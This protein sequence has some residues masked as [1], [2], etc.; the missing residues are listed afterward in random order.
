MTRFTIKNLKEIDDTGPERGHGIEARFARKHIESDHLGVTY[1]RYS[2][3]VRSTTAHSHRVQEEVY[4]VLSGHGRIRLDDQIVELR[5]W[6]VIR[7]APA[8]LRAVEA[9]PDG[10]EF[11]AVGSDRPDAGDGVHA[12]PA[13]ID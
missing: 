7:I 3:G 2:P 4:I 11:L 12:Q 10:L 6:D 9:G 8:T 13:W 1:F 5:Q